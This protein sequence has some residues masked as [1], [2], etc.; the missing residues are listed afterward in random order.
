MGVVDGPL[1]NMYSGA[2]TTGELGASPPAS[3]GAPPLGHPV[4]SSS[5]PHLGVACQVLHA[6][7]F[8]WGGEG[9]YLFTISELKV[10]CLPPLANQHRASQAA[11]H[12]GGGCPL[13]H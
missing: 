1:P 2:T 9:R 13:P 7:T 12:S 6:T 10:G 11:R 5:L 4:D 3:I 8:F